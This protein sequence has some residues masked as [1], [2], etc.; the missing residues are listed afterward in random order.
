MTTTVAVVGATG[1]MGRLACAL[2]EA[3]TEFELAAHIG[4]TGEL[5]EMLGADVVLDVTVPA[6]SQS[7]V[8]FA[9]A[10][11]INALVGTSGWTA[12][13]IAVI[14]RLVTGK[15]DVGVVFIPNFSL[16]SVL[17]TS[18]A[19]QAARYFDSIEIVEAH[20]A[21]KVDS[22]SGTAVRTAE[23]MG[24]ARSELGPVSAPHVDQRARGQ[25][26]SSIPIHSLRL[27]GVVARQDVHFGGT[28]E[29]LT[30][31]H[32]TLSPSS[33]EVGILLGLRAAATARGITVGLD[34]LLG[35][36]DAG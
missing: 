14:D 27:N 18:F 24:R 29:V 23:L 11:G 19:A 22:P 1:R 34:A 35:L 4:S 2:I 8:E 5:S 21:G 17:A 15:L 36:G 33:Y 6:V 10:H 9:V 3:S 26:V 12:E 16:G 13:R 20:H 31:T 30:I 32:E 28:G 25:Q 7:V